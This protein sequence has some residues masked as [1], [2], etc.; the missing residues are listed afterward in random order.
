MELFVIHIHLLSIFAGKVTYY[1][2]AVTD[3]EGKLRRVR[4]NGNPLFEVD[5]PD[6]LPD[7]AIQRIADDFSNGVIHG[8]VGGFHWES[9]CAEP[10]YLKA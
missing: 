5:P 7:E 1:D 6:L 9:R 4:P 8:E 3:S 2:L 10:S